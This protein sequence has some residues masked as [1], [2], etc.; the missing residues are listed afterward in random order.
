M[1][2]N[3]KLAAQVL[4]FIGEFDGSRMGYGDTEAQAV[5]TVAEQ[6]HG[7]ARREEIQR[8]CKSFMTMPTR[9]KN[10]GR[11]HPLYRRNG[12]AAPSLT[13]TG[14]A[15]RVRGIWRSWVWLRRMRR[16][17]C[18]EYQAHGGEGSNRNCRLYERGVF[19]R[20]TGYELERQR[21][22]LTSFV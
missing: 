19:D 4:Y 2:P 10:R 17:H 1:N 16:R 3:S 18:P 14:P 21:I 5:E 15:G 12:G 8:L 6:L 11:H 22:R 7:P 9:R 20:G 13:G